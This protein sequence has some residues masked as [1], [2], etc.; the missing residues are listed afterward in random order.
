MSGRR[1]DAEVDRLYQLPLDEFTSARN[2]LAKASGEDGSW[3]RGLVKPPV[4]AWAINQLAWRQREVYDALL[5]AAAEMRRAHAAVLAGRSGDVRGAGK[6]HEERIDAALKASVG[7]LEADGHPVTDA[8]RQAIVTTL[9]S[10]PGDEPPGRLTRTLQPGGFEMLAGL[11][12]GGKGG[13][14]KA[15]VRHM[16]APARPAAPAPARKKAGDDGPDR[17]AIAR[18]RDAITAATRT[19]RDAEHNA[20]REEFERARTARE[21]E[22]AAKAVQAAKDALEQAQ[23]EL[24]EAEQQA[25]AA[26]RASEAAE[27]R[28][29]K[30]EQALAEARADAEAAERE[31]AKLEARSS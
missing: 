23:R 30:A 13:T 26:A 4:A 17:K 7:I 1:I 10:L 20:R 29:A 31:L 18:A 2:T 9:R 15:P 24:D 11:S 21:A 27:R 14:M 5:R 6:Q 3:I 28:T 16:P 19:L 12:I 25:T 8:T 22:K